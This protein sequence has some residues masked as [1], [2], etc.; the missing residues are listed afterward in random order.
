M[1]F[2]VIVS[3]CFC[4]TPVIPA[5]A[6]VCN[7]FENILNNCVASVDVECISERKVFPFLN[8]Y[9]NLTT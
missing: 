2:R 9:L 3:L 4:Y 1:K 6:Y 5:S 7:V 8:E